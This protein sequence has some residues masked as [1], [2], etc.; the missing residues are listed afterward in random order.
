MAVI[1]ALCARAVLLAWIS[2]VN[3][4]N[5]DEQGHLASGLIVLTRGRFDL[6]RVNPPLVRVVAAAPILLTDAKMDWKPLGSGSTDAR[7]E[8]DAGD[9]FVRQNGRNSFWYFTLARWQGN[10]I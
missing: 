2:Y 4:P 3:S 1:V 9:H 8:F 6:Y 10:R 7:H 5:S